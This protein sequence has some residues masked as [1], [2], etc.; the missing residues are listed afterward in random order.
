MK[1]SFLD[2]T[3]KGTKL[4]IVVILVLSV[5]Y[6]RLLIFVPMFLRYALDGIIMGDESV[7][8]NFISRLFYSNNK[9]T[10]ITILIFVL[11]LVNIAV[12]IV[13]YLK[14]KIN[15]KFNLRVN[16]NVKQII[17]EHVPRIEY[18]QFCNIDKSNVASLL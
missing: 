8:P 10:K 7:I 5:I 9:I 3:L 12:F 11:I 4:Y 1:N 6:S 2:R 17:L 13:S 18:M 16:R 14:S 15:T